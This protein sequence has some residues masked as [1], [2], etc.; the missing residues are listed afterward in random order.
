LQSL[1]DLPSVKKNG[2]ELGEFVSLNDV[3]Y[4][5]RRALEERHRAAAADSPQAASIHQELARQYEDLLASANGSA[6]PP[7]ATSSDELPSS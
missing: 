6:V 1:A 2:V 4:F 3:D 5:R 7:A